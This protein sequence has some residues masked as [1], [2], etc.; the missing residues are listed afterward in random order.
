MAGTGFAAF[1][2]GVGTNLL[3][4]KAGVFYMSLVPQFMPHGA[5]VFGTTVLF[6]VIDLIEL[7]V[8]FWLVSA[9][10]SRSGTGSGGRP[11][12]GG[13]NRSAALRSSASRRTSWRTVPDSGPAGMPETGSPDA[14][15]CSDD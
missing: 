12:G 8:W 4:P 9:R 5:P 7:A 15:G 11:S 2:A 13:W 6:T 1:R 14:V 3:N 10:R